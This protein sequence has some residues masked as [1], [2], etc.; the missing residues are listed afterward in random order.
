MPGFQAGVSSVDISPEKGVDLGGYP[1]FYRHNTGVHDPLFGTCLYLECE[2]GERFLLIAGDMLFLH[3][4]HV[5]AIR[6]RIRQACG[7]PEERIV[8]SCSHTHSAP[9]TRRS[10]EFEAEDGDYRIEISAAYIASLI[11]KLSESAQRAVE[12]KFAAE[13]AYVRTRCGKEEGIGGN[14]RDPQNGPCDPDL[15]VFFIRD[16]SARVRAIYT[17]YALHPTIL[18]GENTLV[19]ADYP[20]YMRAYLGRHFP[21]AVFMFAQGT[22]GDQSSRFFRRAQD[23]SEARRFGETLARRIHRAYADASFGTALRLRARSRAMQLKLK[24]YGDE[25]RALEQVDYYRRREQEAIASG[26]AYT[27]LQTANLWLLGAECEL[28]YTRLQQS[29]RLAEIY[30][31]GQPYES[32]VLL[33]NDVALVFWPGEFFSDFGLKLKAA[34]PFAETQVIALSNGE[35]PGYCVT[36]AGLEEGGYEVWNTMLDPVSGAIAVD[37][38][39]EILEELAKE[40]GKPS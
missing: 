19:S 36:A 35:L 13:I 6:A 26:A 33:L 16:R 32:T 29:G 2:D 10:F 5:D 30:A 24:T 11:E 39:L 3:R 14:R 27:E 12:H 23:F 21:E 8:V 22:S 7:I 15:P 40:R 1:Y 37:T 18:H 25:A 20:G 4:E 31:A 34:S 17:K 28:N 9:W 38:A